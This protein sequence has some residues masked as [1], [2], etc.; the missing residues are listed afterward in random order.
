MM[1]MG[2]RPAYQC[3]DLF[4]VVSLRHSRRATAGDPG[5]RRRGTLGWLGPT[6]LSRPVRTH[7]SAPVRLPGR[8]AC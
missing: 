4:P 8:L 5:T 7:N 3:F 6:R 1:R 2:D